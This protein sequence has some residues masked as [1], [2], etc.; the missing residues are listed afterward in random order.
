M[1]I[2]EMDL[3]IKIKSNEYPILFKLKKVELNKITNLI[4]K[5][6]YDILYPN[7]DKT[8]VQEKTEYND[9][10]N[11]IELLKNEFAHPLGN[12]ESSLE[13]LIG[14]SSNSAKKG[15]F[16]ENLLENI[17]S[18]RYGDITFKKTN[19]IAHSGDAWLYLPDDKIIMLESKNYTSTVGKDEI[20]KLHN[21]MITNHIQWALFVSFNSNIQ[22]L[23]EMDFYNFT[24]NNEIYNVVSISNLSTDINKLDL[25]LTIIRKLMSLSSY[26]INFPWIVKNIKNELDELNDVIK[27]NYLI[28][29]NFLLVE[30]DIHKSLNIFYN[31]LRDY[32]WEL[33][34][35]IQQVIL[36][37]QSTITESIELNLNNTS[38]DIID[39]CTSKEKKLFTIITKICD[40]LNK[41]NILIIKNTNW[42]LSLHNEIIGNIKITAKKII[43]EFT[44]LDIIINFSLGREK[45]VIR[46]ITILENLL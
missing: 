13:K 38:K 1:S 22:G 2:K 36:N 18:Q 28:R 21:D 26:N 30:K 12:L 20:T 41:K 14:I 44:N 39:Y 31:K 15:E 19:H 27:R 33:E 4:F 35:K 8:K 6:G 9:I 10:I 42:D 5:T 37:I 16:A 46:N 45:E 23:K 32:Q 25:G 11:K 24:H 17:F 3:N 7:I 43:L 40:T 29:D 34:Q